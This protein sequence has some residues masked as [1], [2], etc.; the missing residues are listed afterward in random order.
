MKH[1]ALLADAP[2]ARGSPH[3]SS[4]ENLAVRLQRGLAE[5]PGTMVN[6]SCTSGAD[7]VGRIAARLRRGEVSL[8]VAGGVEKVSARNRHQVRL[9]P[10]HGR[11]FQGRHSP[12]CEAFHGTSTLL[13][14]GASPAR[15]SAAEA[16]SS[17]PPSPNTGE[18]KPRRRKM[19]AG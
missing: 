5:A 8:A 19:R 6:R 12:T 3:G 13:R 10:V 11:P 17:S 1:T 18:L 16:F 9:A 14:A 7:S 15:R 4:A 2:P